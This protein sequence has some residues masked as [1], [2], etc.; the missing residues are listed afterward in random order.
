MAN[1]RIETLKS[2]ALAAGVTMA[3]SPDQF[4]GEPAVETRTLKTALH[5]V[6]DAD[7]FKAWIA[8]HWPRALSTG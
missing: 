8:G 3:P 2:A 4:D 7:K 5:P 1:M 6:L